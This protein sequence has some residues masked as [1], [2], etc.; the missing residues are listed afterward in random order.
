MHA[1]LV[2]IHQDEDAPREN[3]PLPDPVFVVLARAKGQ[4]LAIECLAERTRVLGG[5]VEVESIK[6]R[7][8]S[9]REGMGHRLEE[10]VTDDPKVTRTWIAKDFHEVVY[11]SQQEVLLE[12]DDALGDVENASET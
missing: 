4:A 11:N 12:L 2:Y 3:Q 10:L 7:L 5:S 1:A 6:R 9:A 8:E